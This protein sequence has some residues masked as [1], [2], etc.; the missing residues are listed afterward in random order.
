M[1]TQ[2]MAELL[3]KL[4]G[5]YFMFYPIVYFGY[6]YI[7]ESVGFSEYKIPGFW[8]GMLGLLLIIM[9]RNVLFSRSK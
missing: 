7:V 1:R 8:I 2:A 5:I 3:G 6:N 9:T 4:F